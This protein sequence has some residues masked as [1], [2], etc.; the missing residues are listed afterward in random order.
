MQKP[1]LKNRKSIS[2]ALNQAKALCT[3]RGERLTDLRLSVLELVLHHDQ[4]AK[5]YDLLAKLQKKKPSAKPATIYRT[6]DFLLSLGLVHKI[7][8]LNAYICCLHPEAEKP[9]LFLICKKCHSV[10]ESSGNTYKKIISQIS[11]THTFKT[12]TSSFEV[13]GLCQNCI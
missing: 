13:E 1:C 9:C 4:P 6:L 2:L 3:Q 8:C 10:T 11:Q 12:T 7:H 5:A